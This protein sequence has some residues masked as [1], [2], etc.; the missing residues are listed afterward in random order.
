MPTRV[1]I[2][3]ITDLKR[4]YWAA[5]TDSGPRLGACEGLT[6]KSAAETIQ[7]LRA[8]LVDTRD[9]VRLA[10]GR[11]NGIPWREVDDEGVDGWVEA[12]RRLKDAAPERSE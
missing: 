9:A 1:D 7:A 4:L 10:Y 8:E 3:I 2:D 6:M 5:M 12:V 11:S